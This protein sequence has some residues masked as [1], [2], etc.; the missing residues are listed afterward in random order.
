MPLRNLS[1][2]SEKQLAIKAKEVRALRVFQFRCLRTMLKINVM[3]KVR[4]NAILE[5]CKIPDIIKTMDLRRARWIEKLSYMCPRTRVPRLLFGCWMYGLVYHR[6]GK[7][8]KTVA[9]SHADSLRRIA[10]A[11]LLEDD[12]QIMAP[13][14]IADSGRSIEVSTRVKPLFELVQSNQ[15]PAM[16]ERYLGLEPGAYSA[17]KPSELGRVP[18]RRSRTTIQLPS[19]PSNDSGPTICSNCQC[20]DCIGPPCLSPL[21]RPPFC[22]SCNFRHGPTYVQCSLLTDNDNIITEPFTAEDV[23][24]AVNELSPR[25]TQSVER[26]T[27]SPMINALTNATVAAVIASVDEDTEVPVPRRTTRSR[28]ARLNL[29]ATFEG[30]VPANN[31]DAW[32]DRDL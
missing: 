22:D 14:A 30:F 15:W 16:M 29:A 10:E 12:V 17:F 3:H 32:R 31:P 2:P 28:S 19:T 27:M 23:E 25:S 11:S 4:N 5:L 8:F 24:V 18:P 6:D 9:H 13:F 26:A 21:S 7:P 1:S 20:A